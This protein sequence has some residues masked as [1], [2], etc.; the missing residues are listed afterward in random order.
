MRR[1]LLK[2]WLVKFKA[3]KPFKGSY[4]NWEKKNEGD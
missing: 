1:S 4:V 3:N 2:R